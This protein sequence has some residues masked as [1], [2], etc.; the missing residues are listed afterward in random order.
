VQQHRGQLVWACLTIIQRWLSE[1]RP[2]PANAPQL[3][4]F[5]QWS[6][7][8]GGIL[9]S[10]KIDGFLTNIKEFYEKSDTEGAAWRAFLDAW[11]TKF[12]DAEVVVSDL[13]PLAECVDLGKGNDRSQRIKLGIRIANTVDRHYGELVVKRGTEAKGL[14]RWRLETIRARG[15]CV[16]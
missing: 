11:W 14:Q 9:F 16:G 10:A 8:M 15:G 4:S 7:I 2:Q 1:G 5:E 13:F 3:G 12:L 6:E